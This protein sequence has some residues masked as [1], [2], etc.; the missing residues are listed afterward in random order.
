MLDYNFMD[1]NV[2]DFI[3]AIY[4]N[5]NCN[6]VGQRKNVE[7]KLDS[8]SAEPS[9]AQSIIESMLDDFDIGEIKLININDG[10][11]TYE[12]CDGG[13]RKRTIYAFI[14]GKFPLHKKSKFGT[15]TY[16]EGTKT[17]ERGLYF[18][19]LPQ[20]EKDKL[21]K[22]PLRFIVYQNKSKTFV[23]GQFRVT[24]TT[25]PVNNQEM[26]NSFGDIPIASLVREFVREIEEKKNQPHTLFENFVNNGELKFKNLSTHNNRLKLEEF[27]ARIV[28]RFYDNS[29]KR[30]GTS[31]FKELSDMYSNEDVDTSKFD[32]KVSSFFNYLLDLS[33]AKMLKHS[34]RGLTQTELVAASRMFLYFLDMDTNFQI[35][36][37]DNLWNDF[38]NSL[39]TFVGKDPKTLNTDIINDDKGS[40]T[41]SDAMRGYLGLHSNLEKIEKSVEWL[42]E[43]IEVSQHLILRDKTRCFS[44]ELIE[45]VLAK[46]NYTDYIDGKPLT[47]DNA[48]GAHVD[49]WSEGGKTTVDN[50]VVTSS[51]HNSKMGSLNVDAYK[52][53]QK[54]S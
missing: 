4:P 17:K 21:M 25:T 20:E 16:K 35:V 43:D 38:Y 41:K 9:K 37:Y 28:Y 6:P 33:K 3:T 47:M 53:I 7:S 45:Q 50:L 40:R 34:G 29:D 39:Q 42:L 54:D 8:Q 2:R 44:R 15:K 18:R 24:N 12:S 13:H 10:S 32:K 36:N 31:S 22:Y 23:G 30:L 49:A 5:T 27:V 52:E 1:S 51:Y 26:L 11:F 46:Q 14:N 48:V 19:E